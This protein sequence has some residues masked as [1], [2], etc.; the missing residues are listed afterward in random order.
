MKAPEVLRAARRFIVSRPDEVWRA[1]KNLTELKVGLPI[2]VFRWL[3]N[4]AE[5][6]G[7]VKDL[8]IDAVPPGVRIAASVSAMKTPLRFATTAYI[9]RVD[10]SEE[11]LELEIRLEGTSLNMDG[12][13][14][15]PVAT[16][17][18]SGALDLSRPGSL[19]KF[20]PKR[21]PII[22]D[23]SDNRITLDLM[24]D[25]RLADSFWARKAVGTLTSFLTL[26]SA[27]SSTSHFDVSFKALPQGLRGAMSSVQKNL[28]KSG[29][30]RLIS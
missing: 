28:F 4:M 12:D 25:K 23:A 27:H 13:A 18:K 2:D 1:A 3:G 8:Q 24:R 15:T 26:E 20:L 30:S 6:S 21:P 29:L 10:F 7:K 19:I 11:K 9:D 17:V 22:V 14:E 16:L 5:E